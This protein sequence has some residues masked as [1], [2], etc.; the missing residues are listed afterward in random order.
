MKKKERTMGLIMSVIISAVMGTVAAYLVMKNNPD[1]TKATPAPVMYISNIVVSI[2][3]GVIVALVV[4]LGKLG[5][6]L[7]EKAHAKPP[8]MKFNLI[9]AIPISV[10]NTFIVSFFVSIFGVVMARSKAPESVVADMPPFLVMWLSGWV[11]LLIPT[12]IIGYVLAVFLSPFVS[13][14]VGLA[15]PKAGAGRYASEDK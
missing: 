1:A 3:V 8:A 15:G 14:A 10:G 13:R 5:K 7:A 11:K 6:N 4:P 12:L 2:I 9:N